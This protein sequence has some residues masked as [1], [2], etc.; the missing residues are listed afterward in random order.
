LSTQPRAESADD[1]ERWNNEDAADLERPDDASDYNIVVAARDWTVK[2]MV[3]QIEQGNID[4]DPVFQRRNA[5]RDQRRSRLIESFV[6]GF[7][8]PQ[9]VLAENPRQRKTFIV[10]DG[11]QR[12]MTM[13]GLYLGKFRSYWSQPQLSGMN[14]LRELNRV[15]L[16]D[17]LS[18]SQYAAERRQ[19]D[20]AD[21]R[22]TVI[23]GFR[24]E[25]VLYDIFYRI[26]TGSVP[27]S[28]QELR[29]V[30]NRGDFSR[31][32]LQVTSEANPLWHVLRIDSPDARLRDVELLLRLIAWRRFASAYTG[33]MK[34]FLDETMQQLNSRWPTE[35]AGT[36]KLTQQVLRGV[37]MATRVFGPYAGRKF[38]NGKFEAA[39]NR[40]LFEVQAYYF[41]YRIIREA[42]KSHKKDILAAF[43]DLSSDS[44]FITS[45]E[46]TTKSIEHYETRFNR[47]RLMLE[48]VLSVPTAPLSLGQTPRTR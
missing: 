12:L 39:L 47:Y 6:L 21:I 27:L 9:I 19:L 22:T 25:G 36:E 42:A 8:V 32:L 35:R 3:D 45:V 34:P 46:S 28:S 14:V 4:L 10:I 18:D 20:N 2:T 48:Q 31:Y 13:A 24:D 1:I 37:E 23:T 38:K 5:W 41:S 26:N 43:Q 7:P 16:D 15:A 40:A 11:K 17:F 30:L 29:Q 44:E 33:N